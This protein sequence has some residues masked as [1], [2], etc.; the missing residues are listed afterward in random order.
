M[1]NVGGGPMPRVVALAWAL[2]FWAGCADSHAGEPCSDEQPCPA[3]LVCDFGLDEM[4]VRYARAC[5]PTCDELTT[6]RCTN[7][8]LC[9]ANRCSAGGSVP[10]G[11]VGDEFTCAFGLVGR[12]TFAGEPAVRICTPVCNTAA[13]CEGGEVCSISS[14]TRPCEGPDSVPCSPP[15][16]CVGGVDCVNERRFA[17]IDCDGDGDADCDPALACDL[18]AIGGCAHVPREEL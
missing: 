5:V 2:A 8:A 4:G 13:D 12:L 3:P 15:A 17:R 6:S 14:C 11:G 10:Q 9:L 18:A 16:R 1:T 7:G